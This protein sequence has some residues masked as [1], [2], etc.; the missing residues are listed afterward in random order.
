[1]A[2]GLANLGY[3]YNRYKRAL[4]PAFENVYL[5][6]CKGHQSRLGREKISIWKRK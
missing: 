2:A 5:A 3:I 4:E 1:M 6:D